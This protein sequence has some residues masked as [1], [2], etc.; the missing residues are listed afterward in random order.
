V[1]SD[2]QVMS[3]YAD[4]KMRPSIILIVPHSFLIIP[5]QDVFKYDLIEMFDIITILSEYCIELFPVCVNV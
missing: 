1:L 5:T 2:K 4:I 3:Y